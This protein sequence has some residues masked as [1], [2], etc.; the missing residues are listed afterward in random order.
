L[1]LGEARHD[2]GTYYDHNPHVMAGRI[3]EG[4]LARGARPPRS[5]Q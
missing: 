3:A 2:W 5:A 1:L 4:A